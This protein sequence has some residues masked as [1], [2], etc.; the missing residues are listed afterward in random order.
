[1]KRAYVDE[2]VTQIKRRCIERLSVK[3]KLSFGHDDALKKKK[4][5]YYQGL[6]DGREMTENALYYFFAYNYNHAVQTEVSKAVDEVRKIYESVI[7]S[8]EKGE[9]G[10]HWIY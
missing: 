8:L 1:M 2:S 3:R 4:G 10:V 6:M 5:E 9:P 7:L